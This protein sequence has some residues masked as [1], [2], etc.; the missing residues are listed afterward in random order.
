MNDT[1]YIKIFT[2]NFIIVQRMVQELQNNG[3]NPVIK[4][5]S[6][7]GRLAGFGASIQGEQEIYINKDEFVT[8]NMVIENI[9][10]DLQL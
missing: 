2:G 4:D 9:K 8:A 7:S 10:K 3:I 5:E 6:E 1:N